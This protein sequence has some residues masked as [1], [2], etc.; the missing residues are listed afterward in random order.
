[1]EQNLKATEVRAMD[2]RKV[3]DNPE[4]QELRA[5]LVGTWKEFPSRNAHRLRSYIGDMSDPLKVRRVLNYLTGSG[6]RIGIISHPDITK[7]RDE[8]RAKWKEMLQ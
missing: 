1:M 2:I 8:V 5:A 4:W 6:F 3:V 7:L